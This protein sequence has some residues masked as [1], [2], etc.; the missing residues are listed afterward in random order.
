M[1]ARRVL[2][3]GLS[4]QLGGRLAQALEREAEVETII[5]VD[6]EDPRHEFAR[7]EFVRVA[8][9]R[10]PLRRIIRA[11]HI[12]TV[13]DTRLLSDALRA[14]VATVE[15]VNVVGT[16]ELLAA[17][18]GP[19]SP[20]RTVIF[21]SS[22]AYYGC[23]PGDAAFLSEDMTRLRAPRSDIERSIVLADDAVRDFAARHPHCRVAVLRAAQEIGGEGDSSLLALL[24]LPVVPGVL[25]FDP[26]LQVI[27]AEDIVG[28]LAHAVS[29]ELEG[30][31]NAAG[32]GV[33]VLSEAAS[34][35][36]KTMLPVLPPWGTGFA[37]AQLRR[38]GLRVPVELVRQLRYGRG[39][40][41]RRLKASGYRY[42]YTSREALIRLR[43]QQRLR[44]L[45]G[46]GAESYRYEPD[47]EEFLRWSPSVVSAR[48]RGDTGEGHSGPVAPAG[49]FD[50]LGVG[51]LVDLI[52][53]LEAEALHTLR[54]YETEHQRRPEVLDALDRSLTRKRR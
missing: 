46:S 12:D 9:E 38:L 31:Y 21:K 23:E 54:R 17:C 28:T 49:A 39:L 27:H 26:R 30:V 51:E 47:L 3:T 8:V 20:V 14:P 42:R 36:G 4:S 10:R 41:N 19:E 33:L 16:A 2:I 40:D 53:S 25:G 24:S 22:A 34:L 48:D 44:P 15:A 5:G 6:T 37:A 43:A 45:L 32:D 11:A 50:A 35:L 29:A 1:T 18:T 13:L 7:T 52:P